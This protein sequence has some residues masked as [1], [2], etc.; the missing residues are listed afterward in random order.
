MRRI[1]WLLC[2]LLT[3][4]A[5]AA[6]PQPA[7]LIPADPLVYIGWHNLHAESWELSRLTNAVIGSRLV[8]DEMD[9]QERETLR[10][11]VGLFERASAFPGAFAVY[12]GPDSNSPLSPPGLAL[13][14]HAGAEAEQFARQAEA[15]IGAIA[16]STEFERQTLGGV[17]FRTVVIENAPFFWAVHEGR[18]LLAMGH[19]MAEELAERA[20]GEES[21]LADSEAFKKARDKLQFAGVWGL[22]LFLDIHR[23]LTAVSEME[24]PAEGAQMAAILRGLGVTSLRGMWMHLD[25][26][27]Y[28]PRLS[29]FI[30]AP[31]REQGLLKLYDRPWLEDADIALV[32]RNPYFASVVNFDMIAFWREIRALIE[33]VQ[34]EAAQRIDGFLALMQ[35]QLRFALIEDLLAAFGDTWILYDAPQHAGWLFTG[36]VLVAEVKDADRLNAMLRRL[37][38]YL[39]PLA[40]NADIRLELRQMERH[41]RTIHYLLIGGYPI[42]LAP[43]WGFAQGR[44]VFG[45]FP[46]S[47]A[48]ALQQ[49]DSQTRRGSLLE[50]DEF[51]AA[52]RFLPER[53]TGLSYL[54]NRGMHHNVYAFMTLVRAAVASLSVGGDPAYTLDDVLTFPEALEDVR[55]MIGGQTRDEDGLLSRIVGV[56]PGGLLLQNGS[57]TATALS[58]SV[59]LPSLSRARELAKRAVSAA[60]L[61][62]IGMACH[63]YANDREDEF[64]DDLQ[65]LIEPGYLTH[66]QLESPR[67]PGDKAYVYIAG[68]GFEKSRPTDVVAFEKVITHEGTNVLLFDGHVEWMEL[69]AFHERLLATLEHLGREAELPPEAW[70]N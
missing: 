51:R 32:P 27:E 48:V 31:Q 69:D 35:Q 34:P 68:H 24:G 66:E 14:I 44:A 70:P 22:T 63:I 46:Q 58:I 26:V 9:E 17:E 56:S 28:G 8:G 1:Q 40:R 65:A 29:G 30:D 60:N 25:E 67:Q 7:D 50:N 33:D 64:P 54:D 20:R 2:L 41:G 62:A 43:A 57:V 5:L 53:I 6:P 36:W 38:D 49:T 52:R 45:F 16:G 61:R 39:T 37:V 4:P 19:F 59:L 55:A 10:Q 11:A 18:F 42:P 13:A 12:G 15:F 21:S 23:L 47:V 3:A